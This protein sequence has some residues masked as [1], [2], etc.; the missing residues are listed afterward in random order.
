MVNCKK[1]KGVMVGC[2]GGSTVDDAEASYGFPD[3]DAVVLVE[4]F[5][6]GFDFKFHAFED[7]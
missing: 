6:K 4:D 1:V 3:G 7:A 2:S 5:L